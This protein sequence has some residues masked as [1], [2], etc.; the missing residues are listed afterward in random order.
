M[1]N[2]ANKFFWSN[3]LLKLEMCGNF[4]ALL[5]DVHFPNKPT[6]VWLNY[7]PSCAFV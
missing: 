3:D 7:A 4:F 1:L 5:L 2:Q 6:V